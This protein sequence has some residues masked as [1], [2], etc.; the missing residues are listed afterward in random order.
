MLFVIYCV[1]DQSDSGR[2][3]TY[4]PE[5]R[6]YLR[7]AQT[8]SFKI[9]MSGPLVDEKTQQKIGSLYILEAPGRKEV[10]EFHCS[11]PFFKARVWA[12]SSISCFHRKIGR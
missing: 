2:R 4:Y 5:H 9:I 1:D 10:E 8:D 3:L 12:T 7:A 6:K 11:D